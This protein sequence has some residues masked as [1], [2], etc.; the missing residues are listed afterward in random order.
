MKT[1]EVSAISRG[2]TLDGL[3]V[4]KGYN[5]GWFNGQFFRFFFKI[6]NFC[7]VVAMSDLVHDMEAI[8]H[9]P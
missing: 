2:T 7:C 5:V 9:L 6:I 3:M 8:F 4:I 1:E